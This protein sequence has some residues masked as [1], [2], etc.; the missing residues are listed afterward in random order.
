MW[1]VADDARLFEMLAD[2]LSQRDMSKS[3]HKSRSAIQRRVARMGNEEERGSLVPV[4]PKI[5]RLKRRTF[6]SV[7]EII[8]H[9][10]DTHMPFEDPRAVELLY[11]IARDAKPSQLVCIGDIFDFYQ[12][13]SFLPPP[14]RRLHP[15]QVDLQDGITRGSSH[16][17]QMLSIVSP[18]KAYFLGGNHEDRWDK[19]IRKMLTD[20][21]MRHMLSLP[22]VEKVLKFEYIAGLEDIGY[23][24]RPYD[25]PHL[26]LHDRLLQKHGDR[27]NKYVTRTELERYG[28]STM[29]GHNH[30][31][32]NFNRRDIRGVEG[33]YS[34]GC[35]CDL[36]VVYTQFTDWQQGFAISTWK[37]T[38]DGWHFNVEQIRINDGRAIW[39]D[40]LYT[41]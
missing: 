6:S 15:D 8:L 39:R 32:Q 19:M 24:Y 20:N 31:I 40:K 4:R 1:T 23:D 41:A 36:R 27:I 22:K 2:G 14:A 12:I 16:L 18:K 33:G 17:A 38:S 34:I 35:L 10:G 5:Q 25:D 21:R 26:I 37:K 11:Q 30:R 29:Q 28:I 13:S 7:D 3:L 9:W